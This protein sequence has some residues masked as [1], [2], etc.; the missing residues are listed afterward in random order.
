[1]TGSVSVEYEYNWQT[2]VPEVAQCLGFV[3]GLYAE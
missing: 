3:R 1:M 2:N